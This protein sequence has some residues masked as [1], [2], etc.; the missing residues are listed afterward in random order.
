M[1]S[2][3]GPP[4]G[5]CFFAPSPCHGATFHSRLFGDGSSRN[6]GPFR[7]NH[8]FKLKKL[9]Q[10]I[11]PVGH[12]GQPVQTESAILQPGVT[13]TWCGSWEILCLAGND[14]ALRICPIEDGP[15]Q[16]EPG[17]LPFTGHVNRVPQIGR[18]SNTLIVSATANVEVG[19][20]IWSS[21]TFTGGPS[22]FPKRSMVCTKLGPPGP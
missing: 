22:A 7:R 3:R 4:K 12:W 16:G 15:G 6:I 14:V 21:T 2:P 5:N 1:R 13:G 17:C 9:L 11:P 10:R 8:L 18:S 19:F 20:P